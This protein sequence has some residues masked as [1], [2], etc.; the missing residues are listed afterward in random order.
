MAIVRPAGVSLAGGGVV[1]VVA[2]VVVEPGV[3][4]VVEL[5]LDVVAVV[6]E[7][8]VG[9]PSPPPHAVTDSDTASTAAYAKGWAVGSFVTPRSLDG[10]I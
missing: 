5:P 7:P 4:D 8:A 2:G 1:G 6:L 10:A 3:P 9:E